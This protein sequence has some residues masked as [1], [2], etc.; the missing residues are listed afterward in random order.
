MPAFPDLAAPLSLAA[1]CP[2]RPLAVKKITQEDVKVMLSLLEEVCY[3]PC[4]GHWALASPLLSFRGVCFL[5]A[6]LCGAKLGIPLMG[7]R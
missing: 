4:P 5:P 2:D 3:L 1:L 6:Y 7:S